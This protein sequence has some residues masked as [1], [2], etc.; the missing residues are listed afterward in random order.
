MLIRDHV[1]IT[2]Q[3]GLGILDFFYYVSITLGRRG[4][5]STKNCLQMI[6]IKIESLAILISVTKNPQLYF[7]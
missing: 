6:H 7:L 5:S 3:G 4:G 2:N 1:Y